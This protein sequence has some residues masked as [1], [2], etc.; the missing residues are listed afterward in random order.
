MC[1]EWFSYSKTYR[2]RCVL[3]GYIVRGLIDDDMMIAEVSDCEGM[4]ALAA[5]G[6]SIWDEEGTGCYKTPGV[7][8]DL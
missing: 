6:G 8:V 5:C 7:I 1:T 2:K 4:A 3:D